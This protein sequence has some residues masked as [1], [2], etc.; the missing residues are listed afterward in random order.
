MKQTLPTIREDAIK[1]SATAFILQHRDEY[2]STHDGRENL[3]SRCAEHLMEV[4]QSPVDRARLEASKQLA[5]MQATGEAWIDLTESS[6][7]CVVLKT[8]RGNEVVL[9]S[10]E[11]LAAAN[12][13]YKLN[14]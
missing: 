11:L 7:A 2:L 14:I 1:H 10:D 8:V 5:N 9:T 4:F 12:K 3:I 6:S 13:L